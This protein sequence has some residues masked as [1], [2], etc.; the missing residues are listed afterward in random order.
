MP[1]PLICPPALLAQDLTGRTIVVTGGN[2]GIGLV[3]VEQ[4]AKQGATV[5]LAARRPAEGERA[6]AEVLQRLPAAKIEVAELDLAKLESVRAFA[7]ALLGSHE[8][9]HGLVNNAGV[10][11]TPQ[12]KTH[13]GFEMQFGTN[14][15]GHFLLTT[16]LLP[17]LQQNE[18]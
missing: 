12:S 9:L 17:L 1:K 15:L 2:S 16:S 13:D 7:T 10:M 6:R 8:V 3:T 14:H 5:V 11:N 4:L 18:K